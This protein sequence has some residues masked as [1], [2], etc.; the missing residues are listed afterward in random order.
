MLRR[1]NRKIKDYLRP[2]R[3]AIVKWIW[4]RK[5]EGFNEFFYEK[6]LDMKKVQ[7]ILFLRYE[8]KIGDIK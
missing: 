4:D 7:S 1:L 6:K 3:L 5:K 8:G 2:K